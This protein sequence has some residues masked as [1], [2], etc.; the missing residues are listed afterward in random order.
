MHRP[1]WYPPTYRAIEPPPPT[2]QPS[3]SG[4]ANRTQQP[5]GHGTNEAQQPFRYLDLPGELRNII[6]RYIVA[7]GDI[8]PS[9]R[10]RL[11]YTSSTDIH[12]R[13][14]YREGLAWP[15]FLLTCRQIYYEGRE[16]IQENTD[17]VVPAGPKIPAQLLFPEL[18]PFE[19]QPQR[20]QRL[21]IHLGLEDLPT[22]QGSTRCINID[23][24]SVPKFTWE[25]ETWLRRLSQSVAWAPYYTPSYRASPFDLQSFILRLW[26]PKLERFRGMFERDI[27]PSLRTFT[28]L[29]PPKA[30]YNIR[31]P[32]HS[33]AFH[34]DLAHV[35]DDEPTRSSP[36]QR[37]SSNPRQ[38][39]A[40]ASTH[41]YDQRATRQISIV[42]SEALLDYVGYL[43][44]GDYRF[45]FTMLL[46]SWQLGHGA[47]Q[48]EI[49]WRELNTR[50]TVSNPALCET[51][52]TYLF[53]AP[54]AFNP[55]SLP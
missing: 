39:G 28:I 55:F 15:P 54:D 8:D 38:R 42:S 35:E 40:M 4:A 30:P 52:A 2:S 50:F 20:L 37:E 19:V 12:S 29:G 21:T 47:L 26:R 45:D 11:N 17:Y 34:T 51:I 10:S 3:S 32:P 24:V 18:W 13:A 33:W 9:W 14:K 1:P 23:Q 25:V 27:F 6:T 22:G 43:H 44:C 36:T 53:F 7:T 31:D 41:S 5:E 46:P 16:Y 48:R 49:M